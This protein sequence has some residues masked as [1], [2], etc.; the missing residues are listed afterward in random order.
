MSAT[1]LW[2]SIDGAVLSHTP[3]HSR[4]TTRRGT[5]LGLVSRLHRY[6]LLRATPQC[7]Q[8][9]R[10]VATASSSSRFGRSH[11]P[12][13]LFFLHVSLAVLLRSLPGL[14]HASEAVRYLLDV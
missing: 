14:I 8:V 5:G 6:R 10:P 1:E 7:G 3:A 2:L 12:R 9:P 11:N 13:P 4:A